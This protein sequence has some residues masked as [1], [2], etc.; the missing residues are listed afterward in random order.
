MRTAPGPAGM[1]PLPLKHVKN[2]D[3]QTIAGLSALY[4][5]IHARGWQDRPFRDWAV[6]GAPRFLG[7]MALAFTTNRYLKDP[8][9]SVSPN[10]IPNQSLHA[11]SGTVS[12]LLGIQGPNFGVGGGPN[13]VP[14]GLLA[15]L[16]AL[17]RYQPP[18][19]WLVLTE[20]DPEPRPG[21]DGRPTNAVNA[22][23]VVLALEPGDGPAT[24][25]L[26]PEA[27]EPTAVTVGDLAS[28]VGAGSRDG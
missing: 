8:A 7:R 26:L 25:R 22:N 16:T 10:I 23:A 17:Q 11:T 28:Y 19:V 21:N 27:S 2:A 12:V 20:F 15:G 18:G 9:Y 3:E 1:K 4:H 14:E 6:V 5:A 24:L 13:A